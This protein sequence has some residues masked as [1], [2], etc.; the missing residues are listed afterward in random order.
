MNNVKVSLKEKCPLEQGCPHI[1]TRFLLLK[2]EYYYYY[3]YMEAGWLGII[4][5]SDLMVTVMMS[6]FC[7]FFLGRR[8]N[9]TSNT[10]N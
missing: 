10:S 5:K 9:L 1:F 6:F 4:N 8:I 2:L 3:S 7:F